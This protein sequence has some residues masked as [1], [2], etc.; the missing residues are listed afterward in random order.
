MTETCDITLNSNPKFKNRKQIEKRSK[1]K[2]EKKIKLS[3]TFVILTSFSFQGFSSRKTNFYFCQFLS[4]F[5][6]YSSLNFLSSQPYN[7]FTIYFSSNFSLLKSFSSAMSNFSCYITSTFIL[8]SNSAITS[9]VFSK[10]S[11]LF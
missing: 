7:I 9:F 5:F 11:S 10:S 8:S 3:L 1:N 2:K 6:R 4:N